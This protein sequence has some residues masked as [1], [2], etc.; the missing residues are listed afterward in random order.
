MCFSLRPGVLT[1]T[2]PD[3]VAVYVG[4]TCETHILAPDFEELLKAPDRVS[5][6]E[7][8]GVFHVSAPGPDLGRTVSVSRAFIEE[9][10]RLKIVDRS[11]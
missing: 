11:T 4:E 6:V 1:R 8:S 2:Y 7:E 10:S 5:I 9:L 3:G